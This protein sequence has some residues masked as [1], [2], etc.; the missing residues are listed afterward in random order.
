MGERESTGG[1]FALG[2]VGMGVCCG[3]PLLLSAGALGAV[4]GIGLGSWLVIAAGF[5]VAVAGWIRW[6]LRNNDE[7][8]GLRIE[9]R[10]NGES[11]DDRT[12]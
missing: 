5:V 8:C 11:L 6:R 2:A 7:A 4:A 12:I 9:H 3:L 1:L 10:S